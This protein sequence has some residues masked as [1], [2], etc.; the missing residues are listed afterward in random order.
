MLSVFPPDV[1]DWRFAKFLNM[2]MYAQCF[3]Q[4]G[5]V[6]IADSG[7]KEAFNRVLKERWGTASKR[8]STLSQQVARKVWEKELPDAAAAATNSSAPAEAA[9]KGVVSIHAVASVAYVVRKHCCDCQLTGRTMLIAAA[10][11]C[12]T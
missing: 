11:A 10:A 6:Q 12:W 1:K 5:T 8:L 3:S 9:G 2:R 4:F 7:P